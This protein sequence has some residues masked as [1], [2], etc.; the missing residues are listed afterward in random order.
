MITSVL[1]VG[2]EAQVLKFQSIVSANLLL[3]LH[4]F[5]LAAAQSSNDVVYCEHYPHKNHS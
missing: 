2:S 1:S 3:L 5:M 4:Y